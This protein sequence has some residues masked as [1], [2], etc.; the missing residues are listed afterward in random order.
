MSDSPADATPP[1]VPQAPPWWTNTQTLTIRVVFVLLACAAG[2]F[3][4]LSAAQSKPAKTTVKLVSN[5]VAANAGWY[6]TFIDVDRPIHFIAG[7][8]VGIKTDETSP[9]YNVGPDG[10]IFSQ[11]QTRELPGIYTPNT[12]VAG[13]YRA[14][15]P[16]NLPPYRLEDFPEGALLGRIGPHGVLI[17]LGRDSIIRWS[18]PTFQGDTSRLYVMVNRQNPHFRALSLS[19]GYTFK[20][21]DAASDAL[22]PVFI[23]ADWAGWQDTPVRGG[24]KLEAVGFAKSKAMTDLTDPAFLPVGPGGWTKP[25]SNSRT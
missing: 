8:T 12:S 4:L 5:F 22:P 20:V 13:T 10:F 21:E 2:L 14:Q 23:R 7:G 9:G 25:L 19:D 3:L 6:D 18:G 16:D 1:A 24:L 17:Y 15:H 11:D